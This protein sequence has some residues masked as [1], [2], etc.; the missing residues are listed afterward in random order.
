MV[1]IS[2]IF[3][4]GKVLLPLYLLLIATLTL[5]IAV[6]NHDARVSMEKYHDLAESD[7]SKQIFISEIIKNAANNE[8]ALLHLVINNTLLERKGEV[9]TMMQAR[10]NND[11]I[12]TKYQ[13]LVEDRKE[14]EMVGQ[15]VWMRKKNTAA[16]DTLLQVLKRGNREEALAYLNT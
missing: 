9:Y 5:I 3:G 16:R 11:S 6:V 15:L 7:A 10:H 13:R 4:G 14:A 2:R 8:L 12:F 1:K